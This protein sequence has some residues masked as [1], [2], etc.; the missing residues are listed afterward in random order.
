MI[1][2]YSINKHKALGGENLI[3]IFLH[4]L[5]QTPVSW[6]NVIAQLKLAERSV[7][8]DLTKLCQGGQATY[9]NLYEGL[10]KMC[11][12]LDE[13]INLC[14]LSLGGVLALNYAIEHPGKVNSLVLIAAQYKM[15]KGLLKL[16]NILFQFMPK[17]MFQQTGF[18][19][20]EFIQ[21]CRTM[22]DLDF[23]N[24]I[25]KIT[26]PVLVVCGERDSANK[27][28]SAELVGLLRNAELS[29]IRN[30]GHEVNI[31]AP[32]RLAEVLRAFYGKIQ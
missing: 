25:Q 32:E 7:C 27:K 5:G 22:M 29:I 28:A 6:E 12:E 2:L 19:K 18:G 4:G 21:L 14:G 16:Q 17:S 30:S 9:K 1:E 11:S 3:H 24:S 13:P 31:E 20:K 8:P 23:S 26:C 15:P 10:Y